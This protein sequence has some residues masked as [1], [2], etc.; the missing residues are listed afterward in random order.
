METRAT[1]ARF[2][3]PLGH[4]DVELSEVACAAGGMPLLRMRIREGRRFTIFDV[5]PGSA[6]TWA[7][8]M[9][10][11]AADALARE[12]RRVAGQAS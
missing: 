4:Q 11:W 10:A 9:Q 5:D 7:L 12:N 1:I 3:L 6:A 2:T 8:A